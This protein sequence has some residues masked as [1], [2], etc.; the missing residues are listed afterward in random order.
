MQVINNKFIENKKNKF[1]KNFVKNLLR[2]HIF[3]W[4]KK[5][6]FKYNINNNDKN[7]LLHQ[8]L[9]QTCGQMGTLWMTSV[10]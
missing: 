7:L 8:Q 1:L 6:H 5:F 10:V 9:Q 3:L 4:Q 2:M